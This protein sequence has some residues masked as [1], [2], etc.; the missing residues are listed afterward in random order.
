MRIKKLWAILLLGTLVVTLAGC[1]SDKGTAQEKKTVAIA[2]PYLTSATT[3]MMVAELESGFDQAGLETHT[4]VTA[5][6]AKLASRLEDLVT[7]QVDALV[8]VSVDVTE[9]QTQVQMCI[10]DRS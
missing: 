9:I 2:T 10:R 5:D 1:G 8:L 3:K 7:M 4:V 6:Y